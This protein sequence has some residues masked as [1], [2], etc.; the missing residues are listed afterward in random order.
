MNSELWHTANPFL[1]VFVWLT[2]FSQQVLK[3][4]FNSIPCFCLNH[5][6]QW[7]WPLPLS[8]EWQQPNQVHIRHLHTMGNSVA[9]LVITALIVPIVALGWLLCCV[10]LRCL[11][12]CLPS[13]PLCD[14]SRQH[15][16]HSCHH[17][18][19]YF[20]HCLCCPRC[21]HHHCPLAVVVWPHTIFGAVCNCRY[22]A[23][24]SGSKPP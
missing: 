13:S 12:H 11:C 21:C 22:G 6:G 9:A 3:W 18:H 8:N 23:P 4:K 24:V 17:R 2:Y 7:L 15:H 16:H 20:P 10:D 1:W 19:P 14:P 5:G